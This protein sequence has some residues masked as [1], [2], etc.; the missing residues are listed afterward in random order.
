MVKDV[1]GN[2]EKMEVSG[3]SIKKE[4]V[5]KYQKPQRNKIRG[6]SRRH[7]VVA[8]R[9]MESKASIQ[10]EIIINFILLICGNWF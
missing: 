6:S 9:A 4:V 5:N 2:W 10:W 3:E 1:G 7:P 8:D